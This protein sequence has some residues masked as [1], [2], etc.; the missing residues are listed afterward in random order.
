MYAKRR[1]Q[2]RNR[3]YAETEVAKDKG[4]ERTGGLRFGR[5][6]GSL[7]VGIGRH[8]GSLFGLVH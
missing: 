2:V 1:N 8:A 5:R 6:K 4:I 3:I 7:R